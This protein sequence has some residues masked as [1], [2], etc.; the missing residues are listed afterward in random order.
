M[1]L[2]GNSLRQTVHTHVVACVRSVEVIGA[3]ISILIIWVV[4][5]VLVGL[6]I[7]R[8]RNPSYDIDSTTMVVTAS[9]GVAF[10]IV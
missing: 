9:V 6:A 7:Q 5:G 8:I 2:S 4:T 3:M 10:N 1:T